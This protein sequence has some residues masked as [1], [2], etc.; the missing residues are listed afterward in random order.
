MEFDKDGNGYIT[1]EEASN[2]LQKEP[3][4]FPV[5]RIPRLLKR[6]DKDSNGKLDIQEFAGFFAEAKAM[7]DE[8]SE[9]F[10]RLDKDGNG[11]LSPSE[12][13]SVIIQHTGFDPSTAEHMLQMFDTNQDGCLNKTEFMALWTSMFG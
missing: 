8:I 12:I 4:S 11:L 7:N 6:F 5:D 9:Q 10:S 1:L 13:I 2:I 3:F